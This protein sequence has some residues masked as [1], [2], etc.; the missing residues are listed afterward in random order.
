VTPAAVFETLDS[1]ACGGIAR[2]G[3]PLATACWVALLLVAAALYVRPATRTSAMGTVY[4]DLSRHPP[5]RAFQPGGAVDPMEVNVRHRLLTPAISYVIGLRGE[6][7]IVT[8]LLLTAILLG[9]FT[10]WFQRNVVRPGDAMFATAAL[11]LSLVVLT[12]IWAG[13]YCDALTYLAIFLMYWARSKPGIVYPMFLVGMLN[14]ESVAFL[15]PW[16]WLVTRDGYPSRRAW[17]AGSVAGTV[18]VL[19]LYVGYRAL[20]VANHAG[21]ALG[22]YT[23]PL[24]ADPFYWL[25]RSTPYQPL[26]FFTVFKLLWSIPCAAVAVAWRREPR[27][28]WSIVLPVLCAALQLLFAYDSSRLFTLAFMSMVISLVYA[29]REDAVGF[30]RWAVPLFLVN[31]MVP[32]V[33]TAA[34]RVVWMVP[35]V[36]QLIQR[37]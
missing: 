3:R 28:A 16:L 23:A 37:R 31:L 27:I 30:R 12:P 7:I 36:V 11:A 17:L 4:A 5:W 32:Q 26:G 21:G 19:G 1:F 8:N 24:R 33:F 29:F 35:T 22:T 18:S 25:R 10:V 6:W 13:G 9:C 20:L 14:H 2:L 15:T 34:N